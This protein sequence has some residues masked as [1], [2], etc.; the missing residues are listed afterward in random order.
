MQRPPNRVAYCQW[1]LCELL[2]APQ[3]RVL[4]A[5]SLI[6]HVKTMC[7]GTRDIRHDG[8]E[9]DFQGQC[10]QMV[11]K[12]GKSAP[13]MCDRLRESQGSR[14]STAPEIPFLHCSVISLLTTS[15]MRAY[16]GYSLPSRA[17]KTAKSRAWHSSK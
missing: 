6:S 4:V 16:T 13:H 2:P 12:S 9:N 17:V 14:A 3:D 1:T 15:D 8:I 11:A 7:P 10:A 5:S